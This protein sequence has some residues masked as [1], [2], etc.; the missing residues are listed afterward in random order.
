[1]YVTDP[2]PSDQVS[3]TTLARIFDDITNSYKF[4][5]FLAILDRLERN[6]FDESIALPTHDLTLEM[7]VLAWYP[8]VYF[9]LSFGGQDKVTRQL[10]ICAPRS[11][12]SEQ[13]IN[14]WDRHAVRALISSRITDNELARFVPYRLVRPFFPETRGIKKDH[15]VNQRVAELC[16]E[17]FVT[18]RPP[19]KFD[20]TRKSLIMHPAWCQYFKDNLAVV[21]GWAWWNFLQY[22][23]RCNPNVPAISLKLSPLP[24]RETLDKQAKFWS[25]V[26][27]AQ[28]FSCIYSG[29]LITKNAFALDHFVPWSFVAHNQLWNLIPTSTTVNSKKSDSLPAPVYFDRFVTAQHTALNLSRT[30]LSEKSWE[31]YV[32]PYIGDLSL[33]NYGDLLDRERLHKAYETSVLPLLQL[34]EANGFEPGWVCT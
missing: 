22:M 28:S 18:R 1:M 29:S 5:F 2:P 32:K 26:L 13:T 10:D 24:K 6:L 19:Y 3:A 23:Q 34:A 9:R 14:P 15:E 17:Y 30:V 31:D 27:E 7:L 8:H 12:I 16:D 21:R 33:P 11:I 25:A 4:L 20:A